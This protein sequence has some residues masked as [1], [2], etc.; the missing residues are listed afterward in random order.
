VRHGS[1]NILRV[2]DAFCPQPPP[3]TQQFCNVVDCKPKWNV[4]PWTKV[5]S[6]MIDENDVAF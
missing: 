3:I 2:D 1:R 5:S 4:T 6:F